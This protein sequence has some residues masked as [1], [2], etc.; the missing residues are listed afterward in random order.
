[1]PMDR[2]TREI[3]EALIDQPLNTMKDPSELTGATG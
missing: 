2:I 1:M 3:A